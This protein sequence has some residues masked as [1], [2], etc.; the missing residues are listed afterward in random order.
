MFSRKK[1]CP[2]QRPASTFPVFSTWSRRVRFVTEQESPDETLL[3]YQTLTEDVGN[4]VEAMRFEEGVG[5]QVVAPGFEECPPRALFLD[6]R[7]HVFEQLPPN[8]RTAQGR[9]DCH[10]FDHAERI[11][12]FQFPGN[13]PY[14]NDPAYRIAKSE[15]HTSELQSLM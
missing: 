4:L 7:H 5:T 11:T 12:A 10:I 14:T 6:P 2:R 3:S 13:D 8:P 15:E 9:A 1:C